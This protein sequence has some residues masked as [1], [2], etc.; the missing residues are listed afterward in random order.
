MDCPF[1]QSS[2][3][4]KSA[5]MR[6]ITTGQIPLMTLAPMWVRFG[7][8][9]RQRSFVPGLSHV[10][11]LSGKRRRQGEARPQAIVWCNGLLGREARGVTDDLEVS[12]PLTPRIAR[13]SARDTSAMLPSS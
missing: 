8:N 4:A 9:R 7:F 13:C 1:T 5:A 11:A 10:L 6:H 2:T 3:E 12:Y